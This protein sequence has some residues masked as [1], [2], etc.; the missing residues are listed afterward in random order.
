M[1]Y[2]AMP[3]V[4]IVIPVYNA[5]DVIEDTLTSVLG[6][7][8][9]DY[10]IIVIDDGSSDGSVDVVKAFGHHLRYI[11]QDNTGVATARNRGI[12]ESKGAYIALLDHDDLWHPTKLEKQVAVLERLPGV[13]MVITDV[14]HID[15]EGGP[16]GLVGSG[17]NP[18]EIFARLFVR[19]YVPTPSAALIR[20]SVL[21]AVGGFDEAFNSAGLDDHELWTRIGAY[22]EIANI[23]EPLTYHRNRLV[24]PAEIELGHRDMLISTLLKRFKEDPEKRRY[25][26]R[27]Q[28][29]YLAAKGQHLVRQ[30]YSK[31]GR[32]YLVQ[33]L[34]QSLGEAHS[35]KTTWRCLSRIA[36]SYVKTR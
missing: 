3:T 24:K 13:G 25:L 16:M 36:R 9:K 6:Q 26:A 21:E 19:G 12:A 32:A 4:S 35:L 22:C 30:G 14:A 8:W 2:P 23:S 28:A 33:G 5:H 18:D 1:K 20:R 17:Y 11:R 29:L 27:E 7:T 15:R 10:E 34:A 31:E